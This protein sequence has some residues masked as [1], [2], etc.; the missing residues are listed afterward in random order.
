MTKWKIGAQPKAKIAIEAPQEHRPVAELVQRYD[1]HPNQI[2]HLEKPLVRESPQAI[3]CQ[4]FF[5]V[6][7]LAK[8]GRAT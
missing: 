2:G 8:V 1:V 3:Q 7:D 4:R 6:P 5:E